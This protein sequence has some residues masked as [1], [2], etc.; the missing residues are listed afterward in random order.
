MRALIQRVASASVAV[1]DETIAKI[2]HGLL[3]FVA[4]MAGD[5]E[6]QIQRM[7]ERLLSY[8]VFADEQG[9]M[10]QNVQQ[11]GGALLVVSQ[12]TL[13]ADTQKGNRPSFQPAMP[14][15]QAKQVYESFLNN[16]KSLYPK[17]ASGQFQADM[18]VS[19]VNDGPVTF[20]LES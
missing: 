18:Q 10:N 16:L 11:V 13:A 12:F 19:L 20:W 15:A 17:I 7:A 4:L 14:I 5:T 2:N 8:R 9:R 1:S 6:D 3:V